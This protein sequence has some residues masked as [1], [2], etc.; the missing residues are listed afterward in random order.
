MLILLNRYSTL[1]NLCEETSNTSL[2]V[3]VGCVCK[4]PQNPNT[5]MLLNKVR[6]ICKNI[7]NS[8]MTCLSYLFNLS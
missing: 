8:A 1:V 3:I 7:S 5:N 4:F 2:R 6:V